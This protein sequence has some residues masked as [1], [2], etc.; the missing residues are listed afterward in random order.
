MGGPRVNEVE[1]ILVIFE[2]RK[3]KEQV[4]VVTS[5]RFQKN[6]FDQFPANQNMSLTQR[7]RNPASNLVLFWFV[8]LAKSLYSNFVP[9]GIKQRWKI[10]TLSRICH[11]RLGSGNIYCVW[12]R[13][14]I[15][16][17]R[18]DQLCKFFQKTMRF[19]AKFV[20]KFTHLFGKL[21]TLSLKNIEYLLIHFNK[22]RTKV[23]YMKYMLP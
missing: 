14:E 10:T 19:L 4:S 20:Y 3:E 5:F 7:L 6:H 8:T 17:D 1:P 15:C 12:C 13:L 23:I 11:V 21:H 9:P 22:K 2:D 16:H 18:H